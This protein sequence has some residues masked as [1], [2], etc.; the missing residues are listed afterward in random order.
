MEQSTAFTAYGPAHLLILAGTGIGAVLLIRLGRRYRA[1]PAGSLVTCGFAVVQLVV[2]L[3]FLGVWLLPR[4]FDLHQSLPLHLS[5]V[6][7]FVAAYA[8]W[9]R[10]R[11]AVAVTYYWGLTLNPQAL[12]TP[13]LHPDIAPTLEVASYWVQ[14]VLVMWAALYLTW[15]LGLHPD[16]R[17]Y[18]STVLITL[19]WAVTVLGIN[20]ALGTNYGY[21]NAKPARGSLL[22]LFGPWPVYLAI[23]LGLLVAVWA[24]I[25]LPWV[26]RGGAGPGQPA[27]PQAAG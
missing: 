6:L 8:L 18:R 5:D 20:T 24:L 15:G 27:L 19:G 23:V 17:R 10:R 16:W 26:R 12:L 3:G 13:D 11:W 9:T 25:T 1:A 4:F 14:H 7:R 2:T 21:L 22:D